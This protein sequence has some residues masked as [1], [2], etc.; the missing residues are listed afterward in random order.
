VHV[1]P[2]D[3]GEQGSRNRAIKLRNIF[4]FV[5]PYGKET[6][7][8]SSTQDDNDARAQRRQERSQPHELPPGHHRA[9]V[10]ARFPSA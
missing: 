5:I 4:L 8:T 6:S 10:P 3:Y 1:Q 9:L 2:Q 7:E